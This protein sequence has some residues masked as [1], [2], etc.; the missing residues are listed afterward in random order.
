MFCDPRSPARLSVH[1]L[2]PPREL[3][4]ATEIARIRNRWTAMQAPP[5]EDEK[6]PR[7]VPPGP[8]R[9]LFDALVRGVRADA[10][11]KLAALAAAYDPRLSPHQNLP[12]GKMNASQ[13]SFVDHV[14][15]P[16]ARP[17]LVGAGFWQIATVGS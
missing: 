4:L 5:A 9:A 11:G 10:N 1:E 13:R 12:G 14:W 2:L 7:A 8:G 3:A 17:L 15:Q 6:E 16:Y